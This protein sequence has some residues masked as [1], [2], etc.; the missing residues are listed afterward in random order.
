MKE[1]EPVEELEPPL[2]LEL[3]PPGVTMTVAAWSNGY[4]PAI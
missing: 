4:I 1:L 2:M 3:L